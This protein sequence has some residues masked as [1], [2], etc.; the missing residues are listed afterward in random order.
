MVIMVINTKYI[1]K[2]LLTPLSPITYLSGVMT[3][4]LGQKWSEWVI[5]RIS[6]VFGCRNHPILTQPFYQR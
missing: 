4:A 6:T 2:L 1:S 5:S 3:K